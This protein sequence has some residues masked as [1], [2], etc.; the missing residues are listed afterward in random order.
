MIVSTVEAVV[1]HIAAMLR[2]CGHPI[3]TIKAIHTGANASCASPDDAGD[4]EP[5]VMLAKSA[6]MILTSNLFVEMGLVNRH[7][8]CIHEY[9]SKKYLHVYTR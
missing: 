9:L 8:T 2:E 3:A 5:V 7:C 4:L 1:D 6:R